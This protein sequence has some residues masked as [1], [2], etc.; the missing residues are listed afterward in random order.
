MKIIKKRI[1][2]IQIYKQNCWEYKKCGREAGGLNAD[3]L[4]VCPAATDDRLDGTNSGVNGGRACW[5]IAGTLCGGKTQGSFAKKIRT[6]V[7]CDF[8]QKVAQE[9]GVDHESSKDI[10]NKINPKNN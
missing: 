1:I 6:C 2:R 4:G 5:P 3:K 7:S 9:E 8:F 10:L